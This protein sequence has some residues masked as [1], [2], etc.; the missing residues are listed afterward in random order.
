MFAKKTVLILGAGASVPYGYPTGAGLV[1]E[2]LKRANHRLN[3]KNLWEHRWKPY[4][5]TVSSPEEENLKTFIGNIRKYKPINIDY[6]LHQVY[7]GGTEQ[8][9]Q[10]IQLGHELIAEVILRCE[11]KIDDRGNFTRPIKDQ[12]GNL[13]K[14]KNGINSY[15]DNWYRY[16]RHDLLSDG[17]LEGEQDEN[18]LT[19]ALKKSL[20][21]LHIITFNYDVSLEYFLYES[22]KVLN[23]KCAQA[24]LEKLNILHVYGQIRDNFQQEITNNRKFGYP[25]EPLDPLSNYGN[26]DNIDSK[27]TQNQI[28]I[29]NTDPWASAKE[30]ITKLDKALKIAAPHISV[31]G[32]NKSRD[33]K[34]TARA[35]EMLK[36]AETLAF[37][38]FGFDENNLNVL[39]FEDFNKNPMNWDSNI[40]KIVL[41]GT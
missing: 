26:W 8:H 37:F 12:D 20:K 16:L 28:N 35:K 2:V 24:V 1:D 4:D 29:I 9:K 39:G 33:E 6:F 38:G 7:G 23:E 30:E 11:K 15:E 14:D 31:I 10:L 18:G 32:E 5:Y 27:L 25:L 40:G 21:N 41:R 17:A 13:A 36:D 22:F 3:N 19:T 34:V